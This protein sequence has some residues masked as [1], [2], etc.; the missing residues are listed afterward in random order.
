MTPDLRVLDVS[1]Y[2]SALAQ[3]VDGIKGY[4]GVRSVWRFGSW[5]SPG[6]S[7]MDALV[8][9]EDG[10]WKKAAEICGGVIAASALMGYLFTHEAVVIPQSLLPLLPYV[11]TVSD[12]TQVHGE[13][14]SLPDDSTLGP[15]VS[16]IR[17]FVW[18]SFTWSS[19]AGMGGR[20]IGLRHFLLAIN[21]GLISAR[22]GMELAGANQSFLPSTRELRQALL[23]GSPDELQ[24]NCGTAYRQ[25]TTWMLEADWAV[26]EWVEGG[27][28]ICG[29]GPVDG[30][31]ISRDL[32]ITFVSNKDECPIIVH[33]GENRTG[34]SDRPN[35][36]R[37]SLVLPSAYHSVISN[38]AP[39]LSSCAP[40]VLR[41]FP[42]SAPVKSADL[43]DGFERYGHAIQQ[44]AGLAR[45]E[46]VPNPF[47]SPFPTPFMLTSTTLKRR[48]RQAAR[49]LLDLANR[50][51]KD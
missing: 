25:V 34:T 46:N 28:L 37:R 16:L 48:V 47:P 41:A 8:V 51:T 2:E 29:E 43:K 30:V 42:A 12:L 15:I 50:S 44:I 20:D 45:Q 11:H 22:K 4:P 3:F 14:E 38:I 18:T 21:N 1:H 7:D 10:H 31:S 32:S 27:G 24:E 49:F 26:H 9:V 39:F 17:H 5:Q 40:N 35:S 19:L 6:V 33:P 36:T 23:E 13:S